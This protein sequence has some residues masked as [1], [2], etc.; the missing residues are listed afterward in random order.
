M[1]NLACGLAAAFLAAC[2]GGGDGGFP[3]SDG[4][5]CIAITGGGTQAQRTGSCSACTSSGVEA[6]A[7]GNTDS[8]ATVVFPVGAAG[9][10]GIRV[11][12]QDGIVYPGDTPAFVVA[13]IDYDGNSL[14]TTVRLQTYLN[15]VP[16][17]STQA[18]DTNGVGGFDEEKARRGF[19]AS[20]PFDALELVYQR[21][22]GPGSVTIGVFEFCTN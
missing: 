11:T 13:S 12:A 17:E 2:G 21:A 22:G 4:H 10:A 14:D 6:A 8:A 5:S 7:D 15:G 9:T 20:L 18:G 19:T 3:G 16:Q 1:R